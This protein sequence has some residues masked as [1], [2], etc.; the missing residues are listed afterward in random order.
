MSVV[1][2]ITS[3]DT[4]IFH[5]SFLSTLVIFVHRNSRKV[6]NV[7]TGKVGFTLVKVT[8]FTSRLSDPSASTPMGK[9]L[10]GKSPEET[11]ANKDPQPSRPSPAAS[12]LQQ[13]LIFYFTLAQ[14]HLPY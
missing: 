14:T 4:Q 1:A 9:K 8:L 5:H 12:V 2:M 3:S 6:N 11:Y 13:K 10:P 7:I